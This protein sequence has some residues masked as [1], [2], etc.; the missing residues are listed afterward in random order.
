MALGLLAS[1]VT[2]DV[3]PSYKASILEEVLEFSVSVVLILAVSVLFRS[4]DMVAVQ[5][6]EGDHGSRHVRGN[7]LPHPYQPDGE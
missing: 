6:G 3:I 4:K 1:A 5:R 7:F 2:L